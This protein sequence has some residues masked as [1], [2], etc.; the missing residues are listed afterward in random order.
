MNTK[1]YKKCPYCGNDVLLVAKKCRYCGGWFS[2]EDKPVEL[3]SNVTS[4]SPNFGSLK[5]FAKPSLVVIFLILYILVRIAQIIVNYLDDSGVINLDYETKKSI[6]VDF[7]VFK[8][9]FGICLA[10]V[11]ALYTYTRTKYIN[12]KSAIISLS[13]LFFFSI[14]IAFINFYYLPC[15]NLIITLAAF[16]CF[17][18]MYFLEIYSIKETTVQLNKYF[19][20]IC[21]ATII[22]SI[23][24]GFGL[25]NGLLYM[26]CIRE[27]F[28]SGYLIS[29]DNHNL[30][31]FRWNLV[32]GFTYYLIFFIADFALRI[33]AYI[34][35][36]PKYKKINLI[37]CVAS[38]ITVLYI[39]AFININK[40]EFYLFTLLVFILYLTY[41]YLFFSKNKADASE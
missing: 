17:Y 31:M 6:N 30:L 21:I 40:I 10:C 29:D 26:T 4:S 8:Y 33:I 2:E 14:P 24:Y 27:G 28:K 37:G 38:A 3:R 32:G 1:E 19:R 34:K 18:L 7:D 11:T 15:Y 22:I 20:I 35:S 39:S 23:I 25:Y 12:R 5:R 13:I 41:W 9:I 36:K 16:L